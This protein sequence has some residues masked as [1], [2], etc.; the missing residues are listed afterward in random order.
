MCAERPRCLGLSCAAKGRQRFLSCLWCGCV[1]CAVRLCWLSW[2]CRSCPSCSSRPPR[3][4]VSRPRGD[5]PTDCP[6]LFFVGSSLLSSP[7]CSLARRVMKVVCWMASRWHRRRFCSV[8]LCCV[9]VAWRASAPIVLCCRG[10]RKSGERTRPLRSRCSCVVCRVWVRVCVCVWSASTKEPGRW[11]AAPCIARRSRKAA[12]R[13]GGVLGGD[14][15]AVALL[16]PTRL[17]T[18]T[19]HV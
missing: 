4:P 19:R 16:T 6:C 12:A 11:L 17:A 7:S 1:C 13:A 5:G 18:T 10:L 15:F 9:V 2:T 3:P 14:A 8:V